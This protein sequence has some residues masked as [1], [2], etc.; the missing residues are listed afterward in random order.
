[1]NLIVWIAIGL[2]LGLFLGIVLI[3]S[4]PDGVRNS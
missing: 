3:I 1:M 4:F 2:G